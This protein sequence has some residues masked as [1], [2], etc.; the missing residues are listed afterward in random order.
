MGLL[1]GRQARAEGRS[2]R[3]TGE[4]IAKPGETRDG[5]SFYERM[6]KVAVWNTVMDEDKYMVRKWNEFVAA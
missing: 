5:G 1:D 6:G 2:S 4:V 3:P